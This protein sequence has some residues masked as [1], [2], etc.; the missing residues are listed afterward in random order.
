LE[1]EGDPHAT[2]LTFFRVLQRLCAEKIVL[3]HKR[4][5]DRA[6]WREA[7][8]MGLDFRT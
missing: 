2:W 7:K 5:A 6:R 1:N 8:R 4:R 3:R